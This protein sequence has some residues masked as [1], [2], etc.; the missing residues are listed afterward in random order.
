MA[1]KTVGKLNVI[2]NAITGP[3]SK[4]MKGA[5][6][7]VRGFQNT[8]SLSARKLVGFGAAIAGIAGGAGLA[9][10]VKKSLES[11]DAVAKLSDRIGIATEDIVRFQHA[12][13]IAGVEVESMNK[14]LEQF[15]RRMGEANEGTG[16]AK[17]ALDRLGLSSSTLSR[18]SPA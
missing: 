10:M 12:G 16:E 15:V 18:V 7:S 13:Q 6:R 11:I 9:V 8:V 1:K 5:G 2:L 3:F 14:S 4:K 17:D